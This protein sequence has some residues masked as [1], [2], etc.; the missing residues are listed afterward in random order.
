GR[1]ARD[2]C[3][4]GASLLVQGGRAFVVLFE[5]GQSRARV[6]PVREDVVQRLAV[7]ATQVVELL[8]PLADGVE[9]GRVVLDALAGGAQLARRVRQLRGDAAQAALDVVERCPSR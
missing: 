3:Q 7:L 5:L 8:A 2:P 4:R 9:P 6:L 1:R